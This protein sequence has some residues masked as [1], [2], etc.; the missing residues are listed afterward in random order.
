MLEYYIDH[1][2]PPQNVLI[3][4]VYDVWGRSF[5]PGYLGELPLAWGSWKELSYAAD[6]AKEVKAQREIFL[7][8]YFPLYSQNRT[9]AGILRDSFTRLRNPLPGAGAR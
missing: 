3:A 7:T 4:H 6:W 8:R 9:L 5:S 1:F 2:G